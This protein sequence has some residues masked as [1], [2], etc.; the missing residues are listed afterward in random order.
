MGRRCI[1]RSAP[2][3]RETFER[4]LREIR[5]REDVADVVMQIDEV[6]PGEW[7]YVNGVYVVT[8]ARPEKVYQWAAELRPDEYVGEEGEIKPWPVRPG[9]GKPPG[10]PSVPQGHRVVTLFWD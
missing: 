4:V 8:T 2:R 3:L 7:P 6:I 5:D 1:D 10:A 9:G